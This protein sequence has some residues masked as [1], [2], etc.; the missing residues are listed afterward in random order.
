MLQL[1]MIARL[2]AQCQAD[3]RV[4]AAVLYGSWTRGEG[5]EF[6]DVECA[7]FFAD[8]AL[9]QVD[10]RAWVAG[11]A[12]VALFFMDD[13]GHHTAI[14]E[15]LVRGEFHFKAASELPVIATWQG[16]GWYPSTE[17]ALLVDRTGELTELLGPLIG[18]PPARDSATTVE[19]LR[20]N[21]INWML[22]GLTV[23]QRGELARALE[24]LGI[25]Q[26]Y[27][28]WMARLAEGATTH[29]PTPSKSWE[30]D[31]SA[32]TAA[33]L[34]AC[35]ARGE[36]AELVAAYRAAWRWGRELVDLLAE[37]HGQPLPKDLLDRIEARYYG[38]PGLR[39]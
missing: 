25:A 29:W 10:R 14:F 6:S 8:D 24:I 39:S 12:P 4:T 16:S 27:L 21:W 35:T 20:L 17:A 15:S 9:P 37:R 7:L 18:G 28:E 31:V 22:F 38:A 33:R 36:H 2:R 3:A 5:D 19:T 32:E 30:R 23:L 1:E 13:L 26:R 11:I 34:R